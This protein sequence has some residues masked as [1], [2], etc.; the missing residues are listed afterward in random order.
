M[1]ADRMCRPT[2]NTQLFPSDQN[3]NFLSLND[4]CEKEKLIKIRIIESLK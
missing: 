3:E 4:K 1:E 2:P